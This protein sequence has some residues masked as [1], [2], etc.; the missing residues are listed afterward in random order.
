M[1]FLWF[2][3]EHRTPALDSVMQFITYFGQEII[4]IAL[5]C[6]LY[7]CADKRF[8]YLLGFTYFTAGL[9][10]QTLKITFRIPRPWVLDP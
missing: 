10:V 5:I 1:A 7:W 3:S 2:L 8:A 6:A 9:C 4:I